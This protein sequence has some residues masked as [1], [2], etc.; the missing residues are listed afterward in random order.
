MEV[1]QKALIECCALSADGEWVAC[2]SS[3]GFK[4]YV[5]SSLLSSLLFSLLF[6][7]L[8]SLLSFLLSSLLSSLLS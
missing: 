8:S 3:K 6:S 1:P 7:L 4:L 2:S 5:L